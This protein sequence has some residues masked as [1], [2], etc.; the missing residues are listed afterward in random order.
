MSNKYNFISCVHIVVC[1]LSSISWHCYLVWTVTGDCIMEVGIHFSSSHWFLM[2]CFVWLH[3]RIHS[4]HMYTK[5][6]EKAPYCPQTSRTMWRYVTCCICISYYY[7]YALKFPRCGVN[8]VV[9]SSS[10][11]KHIYTCDTRCLPL[12]KFLYLL[13]MSWKTRAY[14]V[15]YSLSYLM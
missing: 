8:V 9:F 15:M 14:V 2:F 13:A 5:L 1:G 3:F 6:P 4:D 11:S 12:K 10:N 7:H